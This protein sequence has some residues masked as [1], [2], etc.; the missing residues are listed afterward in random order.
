MSSE[1]A[2]PFSST[3]V[4]G[5]FGAKFQNRNKILS[6]NPKV[7]MYQTDGFGRDSYIKV[8]NGGFRKTWKND[9]HQCFFNKNSLSDCIKSTKV[10]PKFAIYRCDGTGRDTYIQRSCGGFYHVFNYPVHYQKF[11]GQLRE[12]S[13]DSFVNESLEKNKYNYQKY[14]K[15]FRTPKEIVQANKLRKIQ[16][17]SSAKLAVP[18]YIKEKYGN[19]FP[20]IKIQQK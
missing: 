5:L 12:Y 4:D 2:K 3:S 10:T 15:L 6:M 11:F 13:H 9:F 19:K 14:V 18:K 20:R 16:R 7:S 17:N 1:K 8:P